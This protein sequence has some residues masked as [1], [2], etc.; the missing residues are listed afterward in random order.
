ML[1]VRFIARSN[2]QTSSS[3]S[4]LTSLA[5]EPSIFRAFLKLSRNISSSVFRLSAK[6]PYDCWNLFA[7]NTPAVERNLGSRAF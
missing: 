1:S 4:L 2:L 5:E 7:S 3:R 6:N